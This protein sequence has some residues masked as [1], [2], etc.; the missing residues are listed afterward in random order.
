MDVVV[1]FLPSY[2]FLPC[3]QTAKL[4]K[5]R[6]QSFVSIFS[7]KL[8]HCKSQRF[9][10]Y[11]L[12]HINQI[13]CQIHGFSAKFYGFLSYKDPSVRHQRFQSGLNQHHFDAWIILAPIMQRLNYYSQTWLSSPTPVDQQTKSQRPIEIDTLINSDGRPITCMRGNV[14]WN[15]WGGIQCIELWL[16]SPNVTIS[17][18]YPLGKDQINLCFNG[19]YWSNI[20]GCKGQMCCY[21]IINIVLELVCVN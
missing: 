16:L 11:P 17:D 13:S 18:Y 20:N 1:L 9:A 21:Q 2:W 8:M 4:T 14:E 6:S 7:V 3:K 12:F 15:I 10:T 5:F 19:T